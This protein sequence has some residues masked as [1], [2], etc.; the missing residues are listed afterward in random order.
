MLSLKILKLLQNTKLK[1]KQQYRYLQCPSFPRQAVIEV[2][3]KRLPEGP[4]EAHWDDSDWD[5]V[6]SLNAPKPGD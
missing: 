2:A 1:Q 6:A 4:E 5:S 3:S